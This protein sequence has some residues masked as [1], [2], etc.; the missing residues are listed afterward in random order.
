MKGLVTLLTLAIVLAIAR[1]AL[2]ALLVTLAIALLLSLVSR[3]RET[4]TYLGTLLLFGLASE[5]PG[6]FLVVVG[7]I[8]LALLVANARK[9][10]DRQLLVS[11][12]RE[13]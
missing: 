10:S 2:V 9:M 1:A 8:A 7:L 4:L 12:E 3:P 5:R 13:R 11:G 6:A